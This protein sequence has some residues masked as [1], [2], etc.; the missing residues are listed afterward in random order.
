M[1]GTDK[2]LMTFHRELTPGESRSGAQT[3]LQTPLWL[4]ADLAPSNTEKLKTARLKPAYRELKPTYELLQQD[5]TAR[6]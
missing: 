4:P 6:R 3:L 5:F 2:R 1:E